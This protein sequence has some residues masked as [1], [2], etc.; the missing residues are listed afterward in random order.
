M[1]KLSSSFDWRILFGISVTATWISGWVYYITTNMG[2][3][4][5]FALPLEAHGNFLEGAFA[6]LAFLWLVVGYFLQ[7]KELSRN[8]TA[9][10][11]QHEELQKASALA[12]RQTQAIQITAKHNM[13]Q[14]FVSINSIVRESLG[15][16]AGMLYADTRDKTPGTLANQ[17][18]SDL[19]SE[20]ATGDTEIFIR[21]LIRVI[22]SS[23][24]YPG[25]ENIDSYQAL[26]GNKVLAYQSNRYI[27]QFE[28][29]LKAARECD[30][31]GLI[32]D[33]IKTGI[34]G[35]LYSRILSFQAEYNERNK[36]N[37][38]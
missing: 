32:V 34:V 35:L 37:L 19:W 23:D 17:E 28:R 29:L 31:D 3:S 10:E 26:Y 16:I 5:F 33:S 22:G 20:M 25:D 38:S 27:L 1:N 9:I 15:S 21:L 4:A 36:N 12:E 24:H 13:Q 14:T 8:T 18:L 6:P 2:W 30:D 7:Q 11:R